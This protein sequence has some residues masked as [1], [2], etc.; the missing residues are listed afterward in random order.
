MLQACGVTRFAQN[1]ALDYSKAYHEATGK[2]LSEFEL[3]K[4]FNTIRKEQFPWTYNVT[5]WACQGGI[6]RF[7]TALDAFFKGVSLYP[8]RKKRKQDCSFHIGYQTDTFVAGKRINIPNCGKV[9]MAEILRFP[10]K[11]KFA[12]IKREGNEWYAFVGVDVMP[13]YRYPH[14]CENQ[15]RSVGIDLGLKDYITLSTGEKVEAPK[16]G[17]KL[18]KKLARAQRAV[19]RKE[20]WSCNWK[21]A[22]AKVNKIH[23][24]IARQRN[25]FL[26][27][28]SSRL[29][30]E[31]GFIGIEN[32]CLEGMLKTNLAK[33]VGDAGFGIF[34]RQLEYKSKLAGSVV[35][36]IDRFYAST[37]TCSSC[38]LITGSSKLSIRAWTCTNCGA[39]HDRDVNAALNIEREASR[40][41]REVIACGDLVNPKRVRSPRYRSVKQVLPSNPEQGV[42]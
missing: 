8:V 25:Q 36:K 1:W 38:N 26:H 11:P 40:K 18:E 3:Q 23:K 35:Q 37:K 41:Y 9:K 29:V 6:I 32:L 5:K 13:P 31:Y 19:D 14:P 20:K 30:R 10:G 33:S 39:V 12:T 7:R 34:V 24:L 28:L 21:K 42:R 2:T 15:T 22:K 17:R 4:Q 27:D 16:I